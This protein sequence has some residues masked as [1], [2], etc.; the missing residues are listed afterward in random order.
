MLE[1]VVYRIT[2]YKL[3]VSINDYEDFDPNKL[4]NIQLSI[5]MKVNEI[6]HQR[7]MNALLEIRKTYEN[8]KNPL[9]N[10]LLNYENP[11]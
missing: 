6:T 2:D 1:G 9:I 4:D 5:V 3:V 10:V 11:D 8:K 7:Y